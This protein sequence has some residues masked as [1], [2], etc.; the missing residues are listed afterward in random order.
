MTK[1]IINA[2]SFEHRFDG[3]SR[4][5]GLENTEKIKKSR[6]AIIGIGGV[7]SWTAEALA[8]AGI[9]SI[10]LIDWDDVC[11]SNI[12]RQIHALSNTVSK[13]K[14]DVLTER[15]HL[16]NP[17]CKVEPNREFYTP[18]NADRLISKNLSYVIDAI[19]KKNTKIH[20]I[21]YC[22]K[23]DIPII[24]SGGA[25]GKSDPNKIKISDL[26]DSI[27]DPLLAQIRKQL[28]RDLNLPKE[29]KI[30]FK[31]PCVYSSESMKYPDKDGYVTSKKP[32]KNQS[33][34]LDCTYGIGSITHITGIF[35]FKLAGYV[36]NSLVSQT[37]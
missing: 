34:N 4:L 30:K 25:G 21:N 29:K 31:I 14:V 8:R 6:V 12:N 11:Y 3:I 17:E 9:G 5:Y 13:S 2:G 22:L 7:G 27:N 35:G 16:I 37:N 10:T 19:D 24:L 20:M 33:K 1:K 32:E 26:G 15:I 36:I 28:R 23:N 18:E